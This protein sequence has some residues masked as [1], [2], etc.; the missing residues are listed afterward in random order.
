MVYIIFYFKPECW[1]CDA[2]QEMLNGLVDK[3]DL[4]INKVDIREDDELHELYRHDIPVLEFKD[5]TALH[6]RIKLKDLLQ[7]IDANKE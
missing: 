6:G 7:K 2:A 3:H 1:F 4:H 5:G